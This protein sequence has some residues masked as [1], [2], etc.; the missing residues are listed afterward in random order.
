[1][2]MSPLW[3]LQM[4]L[5]GAIRGFGGDGSGGERWGELREVHGITLGRE[6]LPTGMIE[7]GLWRDRVRRRKGVH[8]PH[9][10]QRTLV[11]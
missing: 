7:S 2:K 1:M 11:V 4:T 5:R 9:Q 6:T 10:R 8:Q 3:Q